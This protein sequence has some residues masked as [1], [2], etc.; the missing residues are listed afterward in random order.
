MTR[1][2]EGE[3]PPGTILTQN[4]Q[5]CTCV[6]GQF[7]CVGEACSLSSI[8]EESEVP[9]QN[10]QCIPKYW[11]CD[12][13]DDCLDGSDEQDCI[14]ICNEYEFKCGDGLCIPKTFLCDGQND[15]ENGDDE[16]HC[17]RES[18]SIIFTEKIMKWPS[19]LVETARKA[20]L[21]FIYWSIQNSIEKTTSTP[22]YIPLESKCIREDASVRLKR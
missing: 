4:C 2:I 7:E 3:F 11:M 5:N 10:G 19:R 18:L 17:S 1:L 15:C 21:E 22:K 20:V 9:C 14:Q 13:H 12:G 16:Q 6:Q 8:C